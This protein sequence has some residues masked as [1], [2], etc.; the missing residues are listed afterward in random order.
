MLARQPRGDSRAQILDHFFAGQAE[1]AEARTAARTRLG[2]WLVPLL[3]ITWIISTASALP[4]LAPFATPHESIPSMSGQ[5]P[6]QEEQNIQ[7]RR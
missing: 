4:C 3:F 5:T 7:V 2:W 1:A 6:S